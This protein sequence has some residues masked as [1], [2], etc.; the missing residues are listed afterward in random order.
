MIIEGES[1][2]DFYKRNK[3]CGSCGQESAAP[4]KTRC[5]NCL[6][7]AAERRRAKLSKETEEQKKERLEKHKE[8]LR[9]RREEFREKGLCISCGKP[10]YKTSTIYCYKHVLANRKY[11]LKKKQPIE[12][13]ER[14]SYG[15]CY[16]CNEPIGAK[17]NSMCDKCYAMVCANLPQNMHRSLYMMRKQ[18]NKA[19]FKN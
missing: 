5:L 13:N 18:Q 2:Y 7:I 4:G 14:K 19:I 8:Y 17:C 9:K 6:S 11:N 15:K 10:L 3:I 1:L 12:R 16:V